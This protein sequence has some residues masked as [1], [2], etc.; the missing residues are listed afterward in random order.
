[1]AR[2]LI[3]PLLP[4]F[5][6]ASMAPKSSAQSLWMPRSDNRAVLVEVLKPDFDG[7]D[8]NL[9]S[10]ATF[11]GARMSPSAGVSPVV[12]FSFA[13]FGGDFPGFNG[14]EHISSFTIGDIYAGL[15]SGSPSTPVFGEIGVR[16]PT[17]A[18]GEAATTG[19]AS[20]LNR[21]DA[22]FSDVVSVRA[23]LNLRRVTLG[24]VSCRLRLGPAFAIPT[25][26]GS[27]PDV[28]AFYS[29]QLGYER[30]A[31]RLGIALSARTILTGDFGSLSDRSDT[32]AELHADF[33]SGTARP[34]V[35]LKF[36]LGDLG[37]AV[38]KVIGVSL[39]FSY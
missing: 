9:A 7:I 37:D 3:V 35:E 12:E 2:A 19:I 26:Q 1:M 39:G 24:G 31:F 29:G 30:P 18:S 16:L 36:P 28:F 17:A 14:P 34:G 15:E 6:L 23:A 11:V 27:D 10:F 20:D 22:F 21:S 25:Q 4:L 5:A 13:R 38:P 8:E 33:G 32:Q